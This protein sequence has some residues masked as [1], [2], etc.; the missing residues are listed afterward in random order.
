MSQMTSALSDEH[1]NI[2]L[3]VDAIARECSSIEAGKAPDYKF[4][5]CAIDFIRNYADRFHHAKEEDILFKRFCQ[6][7]SK[8]H[9]NPVEQMLHEHD[10][11]RKFV[12]GMA[13]A[14]KNR[15]KPVLL[16][17]A[18][19]YAELLSSHIFKEDNILYPM[20]DEVLDAEAKKVMLAGFAR[21]EKSRFKEGTKERYV[22]FARSVGGNAV[23]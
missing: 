19:G 21:A 2:M 16:S 11:G 23:A 4:F 6:E 22:S 18:R 13:E 17:N 14:I 20:A 3:V 5:A 9:C 15:S 7:A 8:L 12:S 10:T 1:Q